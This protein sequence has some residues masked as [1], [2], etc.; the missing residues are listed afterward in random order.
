[1]DNSRALILAALLVCCGA[2]PSGAGTSGEN[3]DAGQHP[4]ATTPPATG[5]A[6]ATGIT[7]PPR[8]SRL[9]CRRYFG[10]TPAARA[11]IGFTKD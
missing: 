10:C 8:F 11:A 7:S 6:G 4:A 9:Q 1:M 2:A 5:S 3:Q